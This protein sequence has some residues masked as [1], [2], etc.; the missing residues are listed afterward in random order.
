MP[1]V[2]YAFVVEGGSDLTAL[3]SGVAIVADSWWQANTARQKWRHRNWLRGTRAPTAKQSSEGCS[4]AERWN[5]RRKHPRRRCATMANVDAA[6]QVRGQG[7]RSGI[8]LSISFAR[9]AGAAELARR[10][11]RTARL[12]IWSP[13]QTP[14]R[15]LQQV[16]STLSMTQS[17]ITLHMVRI[18][19]GFGRR[20]TNDYMVEAAW[21]AEADRRRRARQAAVD[22]GRR[23][24]P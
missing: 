7:G 5:F 24:A 16:M 10:A 20:L 4:P 14:Q 15:G 18:G 13:S 1:G 8:L 9:T 12:E 3:A 22:A 21:I 17:D 19:G 23:Y 11:I 6:L 2:R